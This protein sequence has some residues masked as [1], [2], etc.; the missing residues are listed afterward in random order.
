MIPRITRAP[1]A[2]ERERVCPGPPKVESVT[3]NDGGILS[4][5]R[6]GT[7]YVDRTTSSPEVVREVG[8]AITGRGAKCWMSSSMVA[9]RVPS[10]A[11]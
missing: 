3:I 9:E 4:A 6:P 7:I 1:G 2:S 8:P 10:P 11:T 5:T